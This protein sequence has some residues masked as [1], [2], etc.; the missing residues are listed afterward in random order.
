MARQ[1]ALG[2]SSLHRLPP[3]APRDLLALAAPAE[4]CTR[5]DK[6]TNA[7]S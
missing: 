1:D 6:A 7:I 4:G 2:P 5:V 3:D